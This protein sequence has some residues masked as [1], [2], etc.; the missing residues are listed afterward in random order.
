MNLLYS[1]TVGLLKF[2]WFK[3][4]KQVCS[5]W[6]PDL[7]WTSVFR[8]ITLLLSPKDA[9]FSMLDNTGHFEELRHP[10]LLC[11]HAGLLEESYMGWLFHVLHFGWVRGINIAYLER[12]RIWTPYHSCSLR[13]VKHNNASY[14]PWRLAPLLPMLFKQLRKGNDQNRQCRL[15]SPVCKENGWSL[16][17][18]RAE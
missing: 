6:F 16:K 1:N 5:G 17:A 12:S 3:G 18:T 8:R 11:K 7:I 10:H 9:S 15:S 4:E 13:K 2:L 14:Q